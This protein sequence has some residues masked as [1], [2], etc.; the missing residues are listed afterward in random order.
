[1]PRPTPLPAAPLRRY[2]LSMPS[3]LRLVAGHIY[4]ASDRYQVR[5]LGDVIATDAPASVVET[6]AWLVGVEAVRL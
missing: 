1:M 5:G 4:R 2:R 3:A 6:A